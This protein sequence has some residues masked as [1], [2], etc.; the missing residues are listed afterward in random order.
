MSIIEAYDTQEAVVQ[1]ARQVLARYLEHFPLEREALSAMYS[2]LEEEGLGT[3]VRSTMRGH[4][5]TSSLVIDP[6]VEKVLLI[7][8]KAYSQWLPPGGH[9]E[10]PGSFWGSAEREVLEETAARAFLHN[11]CAS[12]G[13]PLDIDTHPIPANAS[14]NEGPHFHH[15]LTYLAVASSETWVKPQE[16]EVNDAVWVPYAEY[17]AYCTTERAIRLWQ[18]FSELRKNGF[19]I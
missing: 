1:S 9:Y 15:D 6:A 16:E 17:P 2:Q 11:W 14:K 13:I 4:L 12:K 19:K 3:L 8:H 10:F 18:K 5:T 7:H